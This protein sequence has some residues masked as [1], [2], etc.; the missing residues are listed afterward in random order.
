MEFSLSH[1]TQGSSMP[2][3][4]LPTKI[5]TKLEAVR[6]YWLELRRGE[7]EMPFWDDVRLSALPEAKESIMLIDAFERPERF[8]FGTVGSALRDR[9]GKDVVGRFANEIEPTSPFEYLSSQ[10]SATLESRAPTYYAHEEAT[11]KRQA[12]GRLL[13]PLWGEGGVRMLLGAVAPLNP[14]ATS[15]K[16]R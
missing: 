15:H 7:N 5:E 1:S 3:F 9:Y 2:P 11:S 14:P 6:H 4:A 16:H 10:C 12:Y 13:L 8:R